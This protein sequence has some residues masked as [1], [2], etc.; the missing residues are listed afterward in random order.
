M[1]DL[2]DVLSTSMSVLFDDGLQMMSPHRDV[3]K[4]GCEATI[5]ELKERLVYVETS[6]QWL[7]GCIT[8]LQVNILCVHPIELKLGG[9]IQYEVK[10]YTHISMRY[11]VSV[12]YYMT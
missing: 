6:C 11:P 2:T 12:C 10:L 3:P 4:C 5:K 9:R 1:A 7:W 8:N